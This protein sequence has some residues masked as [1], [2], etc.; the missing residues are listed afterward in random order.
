MKVFSFAIESAVKANRN[1]LWHH[2][3]QMKN[4][5][6]ELMPYA[7]MT[8]PNDCSEIGTEEVPLNQV[9]FK[10][11]VLLFGFIP[12]DVHCLRFDKVEPGIAFYENSFTLLHRYWKHT[13]IVS[14]RNEQTFVRDEVE[15]LPRFYPAGY[16]L[17]P[18]IKTVFRNRH[19]KLKA[20]FA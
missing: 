20:Q 13:R 5:N 15:F 8:Y 18:F 16:L 17:L 14:E 7:R 9:L 4:V 12:S 1:V 6:A 2:I 11:I 10:S 19:N 3:T